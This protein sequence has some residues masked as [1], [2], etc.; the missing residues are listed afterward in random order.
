MTVCCYDAGAVEEILKKDKDESS[1][2]VKATSYHSDLVPGVYEGN[3]CHYH[4]LTR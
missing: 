3:I 2:V 4:R 1:T